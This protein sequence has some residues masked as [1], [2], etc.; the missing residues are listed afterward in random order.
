MDGR[1]NLADGTST[2]FS[3]AEVRGGADG[4]MSGGGMLAA[5]TAD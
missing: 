2:W 3:T 4:G 1:R 5:V